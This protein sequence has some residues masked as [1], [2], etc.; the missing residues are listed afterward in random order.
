MT[1]Q[2]KTQSDKTKSQLVESMQKS[3]VAG[4]SPSAEA[5]ADGEQTGGARQPP[6]KPDAAGSGYAIGGLRWPD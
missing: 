3:K 5:D 1:Q 4:S 2:N 6:S